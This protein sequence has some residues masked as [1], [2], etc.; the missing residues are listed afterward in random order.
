[1]ISYQLESRLSIV[2]KLS[3]FFG[4]KDAKHQKSKRGKLTVDFNSFKYLNH[5][6]VTFGMSRANSID[7]NIGSQ[8]NTKWNILLEVSYSW[9][10][11]VSNTYIW[12]FLDCVIVKLLWLAFL[13]LFNVIVAPVSTISRYSAKKFCLGHP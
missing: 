8:Y 10:R 5:S 3:H 13:I 6:N 11:E 1:M 7:F 4:K 9:I 2:C 12:I